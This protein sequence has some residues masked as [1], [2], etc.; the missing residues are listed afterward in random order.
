[1]IAIFCDFG[2]KGPYLGQMMGQLYGA[3]QPISPLV[4]M[5]D[6]PAYN[7]SASAH[8]L[9]GL[10]ESLPEV[11]VFLCI[12][13]PEVGSTRRPIAIECGGQW[14]VGPDNGLFSEVL[15]KDPSWQAYEIIGEPNQIAA[16]FHG[17]DIFAPAARRIFK[18]NFM[19]MREISEI[20]PLKAPL[21][22][23]FEVIYQ[24]S[25]GNCWTAARADDVT[26]MN[27]LQW[28]LKDITHAPYFA[29]V[30]IGTPFW[31]INSSGFVEVAINQ[32]NAQTDLGIKLGDR[33]TFK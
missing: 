19:H 27:Y 1:M 28:Q 29:A 8:L 2:I 24:D 9:A 5:S 32:G 22:D 17:R 21:Q 13:D 16:T 14:F 7:V 11:A 23:K 31:Y 25:Y 20:S 12:V 15:K 10:I 30:P 6:A 3:D 26:E 18:S 4:L 33:L